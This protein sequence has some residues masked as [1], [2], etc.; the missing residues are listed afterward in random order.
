MTVRFDVAVNGERLCVAGLEEEGMIVVTVGCSRGWYGHEQS[1]SVRGTIGNALADYRSAVWGER[2]LIFGDEVTVRL[3]P[4]GESDAWVSPPP[5]KDPIL[6]L[7]QVLRDGVD[8]LTPASPTS[9]EKTGRRILKRRAERKHQADIRY[10]VRVNGRQRCVAGTAGHFILSAELSHATSWAA[11][12]KRYK[13]LADFNVHGMEMDYPTAN[14]RGMKWR[15]G[16]VAVGDE[17]SVK[18]LPAGES[19]APLEVLEI[20]ESASEDTREVGLSELIRGTRVL[21]EKLL[22]WLGRRSGGN[23]AGRD[24]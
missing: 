24:S 9:W 11:H 2:E 20:R 5:A 15:H 1:V 7:R 14:C 17:I 16:Y 23:A 21:S 10:E 3:L 8:D 22:K 6:L 4:P 13:K 18:L 19:D 12:Y